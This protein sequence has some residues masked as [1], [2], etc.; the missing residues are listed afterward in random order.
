MKAEKSQ[1]PGPER[2]KE[3]SKLPADNKARD[4]LWAQ[5]RRLKAQV[6]S[7]E[8]AAS[9]ARRDINRIDRKQYREEDKGPPSI[10]PGIEQDL[11]QLHPAL[12]G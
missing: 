9:T 2:S 7:L 4:T 3:L 5:L 8:L 1:I 6:A 11:P 12:F 10:I